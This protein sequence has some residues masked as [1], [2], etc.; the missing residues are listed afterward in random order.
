MVDTDDIG[1]AGDELDSSFSNLYKILDAIADEIQGITSTNEKNAQLV[2][3]ASTAYRNILK[4]TRK[5]KDDEKG[6]NKLSKSELRSIRAK[7][8]SNIELI[9]S[10]AEQIKQT[11]GLSARAQAL[12]KV[13]EE[14]LN[15][16]KNLTKKIETRVKEEITYESALGLT[17]ATL[18]N[19]H[20]V[21]LRAFGGFGLNL[22]AF[23]AGFDDAREAID[24]AA[25]AIK[26]ALEP[27]KVA[28]FRQKLE[29]LKAG[30][31]GIRKAFKEGLNDP[32]ALLLGL[33]RLVGKAFSE[34]QNE[35]VELGRLTGSTSKS[36][37]TFNT[38]VATTADVLKVANELT[39]S[40]GLSAEYA[41][42]SRT[43][44]AAA[45]FKNTLGLTAEQAGKLA[46]FSEASGKSLDTNLENA[47]ETVSTFNKVNKTAISQ[48]VILR[49]I[50][51]TSDSITASFAGSA[52][53][54]A[55]AASSARRLGLELNQL[56][57][58]AGSLLQF[59]TSIEKELEAEVLTG[60]QLNLERARELALNNDLAGV[61]RELFNNSVS[62]HEYASLNRIQQEA[63]AA[64][65]GLT[66]DQLARVAYLRGIEMG[67]TEKQAA[68][69][70]DVNLGDM[71]RMTIQEQFN[72]ALQKTIQFLA[73]IAD[74][75]SFLTGNSIIFYT[76]LTAIAGISFLKLLSGLVPLVT[77]LAGGAVAS[78]T[79]ATMLTFGSVIALIAGVGAMIASNM[80]TAKTE[81]TPVG[82]AMVTPE[83]EIIRPHQQDFTIFT[84]DPSSLGGDNEGVVKELRELKDLI[85][86]GSQINIDGNKVAMAIRIGEIGLS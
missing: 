74:I 76:T 62:L 13:K 61:G 23:E 29:V 75:F 40:I 78:T 43:L 63:Q 19:L 57:Q 70:A 73:P 17:G 35:A 52:G 36:F 66:R 55:E 25:K 8:R 81:V 47:V 24:K 77:T 3:Q 84:K 4:D 64:A 54:I 65:L 5:L 6:I 33:V 32:A 16:E 44:A 71:Q 30:L 82:D 46:L 28:S 38:R 83:G 79:M 27:G 86:A 21:G 69:A 85:K 49:D 45:E 56:D 9:E 2:N 68:L 20:R 34:V 26:N 1:K 10:S 58:I 14:Q 41:F 11:E 53:A 31:P 48:G 22:G 50:A 80:K 67:M 15:I 7:V 42:S 60:R 59:Q 51:A 39:R 37:A 12:L 72:K 18:E